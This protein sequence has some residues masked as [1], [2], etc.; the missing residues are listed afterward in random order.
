V[1]RIALTRLVKGS[2]IYGIGS[3]LQR[4]IGLLLLPL[5][6]SV[7]T[8]E[9]YG[10]VAL[11]SLIGIAMSGLL[12]LGTGNS[13]SLL[14]FKQEDLS[15]RPTIIW[16]TVVLMTLNGLLWYSLLWLIAPIVSELMFKTAEYANLIRLTFLGSVLV[17]IT[18]PWL[19]FLRMEELAKKYVVI[20]V[21]G[22][23]LTT[24]ISVFLVLYMH[25][26]VVGLLLAGTL[27]SAIMLGVAW[28]VVGR[29]IGYKI[30]LNLLLPLVR[31]GFPSTFGLLAFLLIDYAD[32]QMIERM[33]GLG[34]LGIYSVGYSFGMVIMV[35]M[36]AFATA[37]PPFFMSYINK[38]D[39]ARKVFAHVLTYY[40]LGFGSLV[41]LFFLVARPIT[42][43]M[44]APNFHDAW[45]VVGLVAAGYALK[46]CYLILLPGIYFSSK[47]KW[48]SIIEWVAAIMN[49][50][51][52][53]LLI[54]IYGILGAAIA[55]FISY[56]SLPVLAWSITRSHLKVDYE[57]A[58]I[59]IISLFIFSFSLLAYFL[60]KIFDEIRLPIL[61]LFVT[62]LI[63]YALSVYFFLLK[64]QERQLL[65]KFAWQ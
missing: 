20:T 22:G 6:T 54:P 47:L 10:I 41:V 14:Y 57:W 3:T 64:K 39:E 33:L 52:N 35:A 27:G 1:I 25:L 36:T 60:S 37:W 65:M 28:L 51:L 40:V 18:N 62:I 58:R 59:G 46:G 50:G 55:T 34:D 44:T 61:G 17:A 43:L 30:D 12:T 23:L 4:F 19:L 42:L 56:L 29:E 49:I 2:L 32:R 26:G 13:M 8:P 45:V 63:S 15:K 48:Q 16:T 9:D 21:G 38:K 31:I 53:I 7:L 24:A 5:F 11:I